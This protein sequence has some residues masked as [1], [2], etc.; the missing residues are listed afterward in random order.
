MARRFR[1]AAEGGR[2][3]EAAMRGWYGE[4][5]VSIQDDSVDA[6]VV[7]ALILMIG[8]SSFMADG[9]SDSRRLFYSRSLEETSFPSADW[10]NA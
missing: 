7:P 3:K 10:E 5:E 4:R 8:G 9:L 6:V 2:V 1:L